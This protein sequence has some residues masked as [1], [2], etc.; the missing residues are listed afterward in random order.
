MRVRIPPS[1]SPEEKAEFFTLLL[2]DFQ[3]LA[4]DS[5]MESSAPR[6][7]GYLPNSRGILGSPKPSHLHSRHSSHALDTLRS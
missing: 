2:F 7:P 5:L 3:E 1:Q 4:T 6:A